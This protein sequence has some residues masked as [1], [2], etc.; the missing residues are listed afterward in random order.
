MTY[1]QIADL[2]F[3]RTDYND[4]VVF[5]EVG[6][7]PYFMTYELTE[8]ISMSYEFGNDNVRLL[9]CDKEGTI[10]GT[11]ILTEIQEIESMIKFY[12]G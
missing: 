8:D 4:N 9:R 5:N 2:K 12:K 7:H 6:V 11:I 1:K 10:K 3:K